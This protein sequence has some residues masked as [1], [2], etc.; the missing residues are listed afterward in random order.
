MAEESQ[1]VVIEM[2]TQKVHSLSNGH[3]SERPD[4]IKAVKDVFRTSTKGLHDVDEL[5]GVLHVA[6]V[7]SHIFREQL[8]QLLGQAVAWGTDGANDGNKELTS[9]RTCAS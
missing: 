6:W 9:L 1:D 2:Q 4:N 5:R 8:S 7:V 3:H